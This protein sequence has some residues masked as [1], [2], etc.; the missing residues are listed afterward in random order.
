[1]VK[2][3]LLYLKH[4]S[5]NSSKI[6][7]AAELLIAASKFKETA[8]IYYGFGLLYAKQNDTE[9]SNH[10]LISALEINSKSPL[11]DFSIIPD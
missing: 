9:K 7:R 3:A 2:L 8:E 1:M 6:D 5:D 10:Y 4:F 11:L